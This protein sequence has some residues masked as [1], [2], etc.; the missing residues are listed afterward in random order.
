MDY[1]YSINNEDREA[2]CLR[3]A[4]EVNMIE[5]FKKLNI[6]YMKVSKKEL[7]EKLTK[8]GIVIQRNINVN[9]NNEFE[10]KVFKNNNLYAEF[11]IPLEVATYNIYFTNAN[12]EYY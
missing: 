11:K 6:P 8:K 3:N 9:K 4:F 10:F 2:V 12:V 7:L 5:I 1:F